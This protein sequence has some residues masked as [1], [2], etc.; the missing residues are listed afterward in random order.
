MPTTTPLDSETDELRSKIHLFK[1]MNIVILIV[2]G[3]N[4]LILILLIIHI[5]TEPDL[6]HRVQ[7]E[8]CTWPHTFRRF[9]SDFFRSTKTCVAT[10]II[11]FMTIKWWNGS[12]L[13]SAL[14]RFSG[15]PQY[16]MRV[17]KTLFFYLSS[18]LAQGH[19]KTVFLEIK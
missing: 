12:I 5:H 8:I 3:K 17:D 18:D 4:N 14:R 1:T 13:L 16:G 19:Y 2:I 10:D 15:T 9:V 7:C 6:V 11:I